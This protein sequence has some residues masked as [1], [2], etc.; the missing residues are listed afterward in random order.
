MILGPQ[1]AGK[2][3]FL[4]YF[5]KDIFETLILMDFHK[6]FVKNH[7]TKHIVFLLFCASRVMFF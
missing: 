7:V 3:R 5:W 6:I 2:F 4:R 1:I